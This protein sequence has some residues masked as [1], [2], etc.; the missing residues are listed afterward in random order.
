MNF[1][2]CFY[3][4]KNLGGEVA[5]LIKRNSA[6]LIKPLKA[7]GVLD[8]FDPPIFVVSGLCLASNHD[9][10][11]NKIAEGRIYTD[12]LKTGNAYNGQIREFQN[13]NLETIEKINKRKNSYWSLMYIFNNPLYD[14]Q[15]ALINPSFS[16]I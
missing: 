5:P 6:K 13:Y 7:V 3:T 12:N 9:D 16:K 1:S 11:L 15:L 10:L 14:K 4:T 2:R 8:K